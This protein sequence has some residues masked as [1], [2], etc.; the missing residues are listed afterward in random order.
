M[1]FMAKNLEDDLGGHSGHSP[2][3]YLHKS[4]PNGFNPP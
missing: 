1:A 4:L 2:M 3:D